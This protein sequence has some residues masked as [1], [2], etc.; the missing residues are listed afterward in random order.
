MTIQCGKNVLV[1]GKMADM[2]NV[3]IQG[4][5]NREVYAMQNN[6]LQTTLFD[7]EMPYEECIKPLMP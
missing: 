7:M 3:E 6:A 1:A 5:F 2:E 4:Q